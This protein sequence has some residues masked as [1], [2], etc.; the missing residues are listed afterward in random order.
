MFS[1]VNDS[2]PAWRKL[3][4]VRRKA[5]FVSVPASLAMYAFRSRDNSFIGEK[6]LC[7]TAAGA[8]GGLT[9]DGAGA[10]RLDAGA[11][12]LPIELSMTFLSLDEI[13]DR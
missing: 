1:V 12:V 13:V 6:F 5:L 9:T 3:R 2:A 8:A 11:F 10:R 7:G 4:L